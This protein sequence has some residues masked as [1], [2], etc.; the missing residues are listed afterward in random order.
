MQQD[1]ERFMRVALEEAK[2]SGAAGNRAIGAIIVHEGKVVGR[3]GPRPDAPKNPT[4][5]CE[6]LAIQEAAR[7]LGRSDMTGCTLYT[8]MAPCPMCCGTLI[9][10]HVSTLVVGGRTPPGQGSSGDYTE[11]KLMAMTGWDKTGRMVQGVLFDECMAILQEWEAKRGIV[12]PRP[13]STR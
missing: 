10:N 9:I 2:K 4:G 1:H 13:G 11:A 3:S 7:T 8:T 12:G 5:H 6:V